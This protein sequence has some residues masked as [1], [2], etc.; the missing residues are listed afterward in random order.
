MLQKVLGVLLLAV[1][2]TTCTTQTQ[3]QEQPRSNIAGRFYQ[4]AISYQEQSRY[5]SAYVWLNNALRHSRQNHQNLL[6][7]KI[8]TQLGVL[9]YKNHNYAAAE[10][11]CV[12]A[13]KILPKHQDKQ[14]AYIYS[15]LASI[16]KAKNNKSKFVFYNDLFYKIA[17]QQ[18]D[19]L[20]AFI[21]YHNNTGNFYRSNKQFNKALQ[22]YNQVIE[23][24]NLKKKYPN[25][26]ARVLNN[27]AGVLINLNK[28]EKAALNLLQE[29]EKIY[30]SQNNVFGLVKNYLIYANYYQKIS[31]TLTAQKYA[32]K[33][34]KIAKKNNLI[35]LYPDIYKILNDTD[36]RNSQ[37]Y[38]K[39]Y[40]KLQDS[41]LEQERL[42]NDRSAL[43]R[44]ETTQKEKMIKEQQLE[45]KNQKKMMILGS[46]VML[47]VLGGATVFYR[48][49][50]KIKQQYINLEQQDEKIRAQHQKLQQQHE[51]ITAL[52]KEIHHRIKNNLA[53]LS[54]M[55][56]HIKK[57][58]KDKDVVERLSDLQG[59]IV[60]INKIH[61]HIYS[62]DD[63]QNINLKIYTDHLIAYFK[64]L[65][66]AHDIRIDNKISEN[67]QLNFKTTLSLGIIIFEFLTNSYKYAFKNKTGNQIFIQMTQTA[68]GKYVLEIKNNGSG[69][70]LTKLDHS[71]SF[72]LQLIKGLTK[73]LGGDFSF[74]NNDGFGIKIVF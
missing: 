56:E 8:Y 7:A 35:A 52:H 25:R 42:L 13:L 69:V 27:K 21:K 30:T 19:T 58:F 55:I 44:F 47:L 65:H 34:L 74:L 5:D 39:N 18:T 9:D 72:G 16:S 20:K 54:G 57:D 24:N 37:K 61:E 2:F 10:A 66:Q 53:I 15:L 63:F 60:V 51:M 48:Q 40:V 31:D 6:T 49:K 26:Y 17:K 50:K 73:Q 41:M 38:F 3:K 12:K 64:Q 32:R 70:D 59:K 62:K 14:R 71:Q 36:P 43:I 28:E 33:A 23:K 68:S 45:I 29:V 11:D 4:K 22:H 1:F 46:V 67:I